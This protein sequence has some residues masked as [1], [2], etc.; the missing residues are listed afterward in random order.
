MF[1][2][3]DIICII[4]SIQLFNEIARLCHT[5][6]HSLMQYGGGARHADR[7]VAFTLVSR[8]MADE[9]KSEEDEDANIVNWDGPD[10]LVRNRPMRKQVQ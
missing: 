2:Y 10:D 9:K 5:I 7:P 6:I 8:R 4:Q 3:D 1:Q